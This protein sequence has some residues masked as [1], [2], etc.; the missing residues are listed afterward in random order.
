MQ[1][2]A[3]RHMHVLFQHAFTEIIITDQWLTLN[4][5]T[6]MHLNGPIW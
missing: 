1:K 3:P 2:L 6:A 4:S 5:V